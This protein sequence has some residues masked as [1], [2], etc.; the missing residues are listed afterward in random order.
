MGVFCLS[1]YCSELLDVRMLGQIFL[2]LAIAG[3]WAT[4]IEFDNLKPEVHS[5]VQT[6]LTQIREALLR[7]EEKVSLMSQ[8]VF[9]SQTVCLC[10]TLRLDSHAK[11]QLPVSLTSLFRPVSMMSPDLEFIALTMLQAQGFEKSKLFSAQL[12]SLF[13]ISK[14]SLL[15]S[16]TYD[17]GIRT[18]K[19]VI[20]EMREVKRNNPHASELKSLLRALQNQVLL[21]MD[22]NDQIMFEVLC[23]TRLIPELHC[24]RLRGTRFSAAEEHRVL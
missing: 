17:F 22:R 5:V 23:K 10:A 3:V 7:K 13:K 20:L 9:L 4:F 19:S 24:R 2:G 16:A 21:R 1:V 15:H 14:E 11:K 6:V 12:V 8:E 18:L